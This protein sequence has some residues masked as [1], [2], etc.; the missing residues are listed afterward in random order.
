MFLS[1]ILCLAIVGVFVGA[2][3]E[4]AARRAAEGQA[5]PNNAKGTGHEG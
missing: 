2:L 5:V 1:F 3:E 4:N